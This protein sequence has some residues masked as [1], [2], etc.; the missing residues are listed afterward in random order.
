MDKILDT[1]GCLQSTRIHVDR[2]ESKRQ[3]ETACALKHS[4]LHASH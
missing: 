4:Q 3:W 2:N 1:A